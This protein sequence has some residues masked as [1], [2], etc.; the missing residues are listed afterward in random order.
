MSKEPKEPLV[1][2][3]PG[4]VYHDSCAIME[5]L[6]RA[7]KPGGKCSYYERDKGGK[8]KSGKSDTSNEL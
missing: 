3:L 8:K 2:P 6:G 7:P 4:C 5:I 1:C